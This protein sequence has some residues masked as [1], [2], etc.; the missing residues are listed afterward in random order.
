MRAAAVLLHRR[1]GRR[2]LA[3]G[4]SAGGHLT[5]MLMAT[6]WRALGLTA[7]LVPAGLPISGLFELLP[8]LP[9]T[10]VTPA[11]RL[12]PADATALSPALLPPPAGV[13]L[14][15]VVGG[16]ESREFIRQ[17]RDFAAAWGGSWEALAGANHF[18]VLAPL[19]DPSSA[20]VARAAAMAIAAA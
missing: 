14:H 9:T 1:S 6:D 16:A 12:S 2:L 10:I 3:T 17:S 13:P 4:H 7:G 15:A 18:T 5:G 20:L 11:L 8:L 19:S